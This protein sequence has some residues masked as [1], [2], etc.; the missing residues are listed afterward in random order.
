MSDVTTTGLDA[1]YAAT[2]GLENRVQGRLR[3]VA[4]A[5]AFRI[6]VRAQALLKAQTHGTGATAEAIGIIDDHAHKRYQVISQAPV[7]KPG[8]LPVW[9]E[10]G[11]AFQTARPY[12]R[13][14]ADAERLNYETAMINAAVDEV[15]GVLS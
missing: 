8:N 11:T 9:I 13:P 1:M 6:K 7:G 5:T 15:R 2:R 14:A 3:A 4:A 12:M 10:Y